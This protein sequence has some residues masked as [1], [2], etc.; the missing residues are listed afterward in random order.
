MNNTLW[1]WEN[2]FNISGQ[3]LSK[4]ALACAL[5]FMLVDAMRKRKRRKRQND[6][7]PIAEANARE[8][9]EWRY[10]WWGMNFLKIVASVYFILTVIKFLLA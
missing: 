5:I 2:Y 10:F 3:T 4:F 9:H 8:R 1:C 6:E 7:G